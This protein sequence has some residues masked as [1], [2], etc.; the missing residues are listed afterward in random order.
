MGESAYQGGGFLAG[1]PDPNS[2]LTPEKLA[3]DV[4]RM[5]AAA[6][7]FMRGEVLPAADRIEAKEPDLLPN[8]LRLSAGLGLLA[9]DIPEIYG[10]LGLSR[11]ASARVAEALAVEPSFAVSHS[12]HT[13][14]ATLPLLFF[15]KSEQKQKY[16][17]QLASG[18][19]IGAYALSEAHAGTDAMAARTRAEPSPDGKSFSLTGEKMWITNAAFAS[20]FTVFAKVDDRMT[21]FM[22]GL[23]SPGVSVGREEHKLGLKGSS[24]CRL[25]LENAVVPADNALGEIGE[26]G[27]IA[28]LALNLGRFKI[29]ASSVGQCKNLIGMA[30]KYATQRHAFGKTISEFGLIQEKLAAMAARTFAAESML[31]R[32][33]GY[34]DEA[35]SGIDDHAADAC[36]RRQAAAAEYAVECAI[37]KVYCTEALGFVADEAVQIFGGY[38]YSEEYPVARAWRDARITRIYEGTNEINRVNISGLILRRIE[39]GQLIV[40][41]EHV[42]NLVSAVRQRAEQQIAG[43]FADFLIMEFAAQSMK[44]RARN[45]GPRR[46]EYEAAHSLVS[47]Q[48]Y[49]SEFSV[50]R[51]LTGTLA[52]EDC[53]WPSEL[54]HQLLAP[55]EVLPLQTTLAEAVIAREGYPW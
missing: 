15:G 26:G 27:R 7:E 10:G 14:V 17:P 41:D 5:A 2:V 45:A 18:E 50:L 48:L 12:V 22:V 25:I 55:P 3:P 4:L 23:D 40:D 8:L 30:A 37:A 13:T 49:L 32:L 21:A 53:A 43:A 54:L 31:Y 46:S 36:A 38:G 39:S 42:L 29:G 20:L 6:A 47:N 52:T 28:L 16:L 34:L 19:M 51:L 44:Y 9:T 24:T 1:E 11:S 35:F 33:A